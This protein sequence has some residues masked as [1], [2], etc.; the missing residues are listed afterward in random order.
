MEN[1][2]IKTKQKERKQCEKYQI[3]KHEI[4]ITTDFLKHTD[5]IMKTSWS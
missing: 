5:Y 3:Q 2:N 1:A 4:K